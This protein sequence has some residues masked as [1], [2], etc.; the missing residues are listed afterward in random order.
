[1]TSQLWT[2]I[3][4]DAQVSPGPAARGWGRKEVPPPELRAP[5]KER[6]LR[7]PEGQRVVEDVYVQQ[8]V[9]AF[10]HTWY[11][12]QCRWRAPRPDQSSFAGGQRL[13]LIL[14]NWS[15]VSVLLS[16]RLC[17]L[18]PVAVRRVSLLPF[19]SARVGQ[20]KSPPRLP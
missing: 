9:W 12:Y 15:C 10:G 3:R 13:R 6:L 8:V 4:R 18:F 17:V 5:R 1:M 7:L 20:M 11:R 2:F 16:A 19:R 14:S